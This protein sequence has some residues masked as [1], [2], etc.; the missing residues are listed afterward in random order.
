[1]L[2]GFWIRFSTS[3]STSCVLKSSVSFSTHF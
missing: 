1:L 2:M 3:F